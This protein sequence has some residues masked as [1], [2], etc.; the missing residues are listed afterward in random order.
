MVQSIQFSLHDV[1]ALTA[2]GSS[3]DNEDSKASF[4]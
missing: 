4:T 3:F 2:A 1:A